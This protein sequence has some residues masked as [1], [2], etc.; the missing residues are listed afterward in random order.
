MY[1]NEKPNQKSSENTRNSVT[2]TSRRSTHFTKS[3]HKI[4]GKDEMKR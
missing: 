4:A 1:G 2:R 3:G